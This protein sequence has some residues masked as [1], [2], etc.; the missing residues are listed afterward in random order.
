MSVSAK[1]NFFNNRQCAANFSVFFDMEDSR[2]YLVSLFSSGVGG[3]G[4]DMGWRI[5]FV[6]G[7]ATRLL[8]SLIRM[9]EIIHA[10]EKSKT[11]ETR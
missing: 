8:L 3:G 6:R 1:Q 5:C 11:S 9:L 2:K 7:V 10:R 4:G